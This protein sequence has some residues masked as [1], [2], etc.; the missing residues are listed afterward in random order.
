MKVIANACIF[1]NFRTD[2][3]V[4]NHVFTGDSAVQARILV[5]PNITLKLDISDADTAEIA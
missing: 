3:S 2:L 5:M 4:G 1:S